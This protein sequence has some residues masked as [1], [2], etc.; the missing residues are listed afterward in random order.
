MNEIWQ[1][2]EDLIRSLGETTTWSREDRRRLANALAVTGPVRIGDVRWR[3]V[4]RAATTIGTV[5]SEG[6]LDCDAW[7]AYQGLQDIPHAR[8][9]LG[10]P[11][12]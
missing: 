1:T 8:T 11:E 2:M 10:P 7:V 6:F 4:G 12:T 5:L 3:N 9:I